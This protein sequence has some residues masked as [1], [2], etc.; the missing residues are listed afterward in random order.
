[1]EAAELLMAYINE[2]FVDPPSTW[3]EHLFEELVYSRW[4]ADQILYLLMDRPF[5][6]PESVVECFLLKMALYSW[7]CKSEKQA[8]IYSIAED[9]AEEILHLFADPSKFTY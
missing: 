1:M 2:H 6:P 5:E 3:N 7:S 8:R 9:T 4:A